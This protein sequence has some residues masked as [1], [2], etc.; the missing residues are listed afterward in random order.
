MEG[1]PQH[2]ICGLVAIRDTQYQQRMGAWS[3]F[4]A[5]LNT[6]KLWVRHGQHWPTVSPAICLSRA[7]CRFR[8]GSLH[9]TRCGG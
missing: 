3:L 2:M 9:Q 8:P 7:S 4:R 5:A 6:P 1:S